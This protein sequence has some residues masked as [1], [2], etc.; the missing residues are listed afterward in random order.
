MLFQIEDV[1]EPDPETEED[2]QDPKTEKGDQ[3]LNLDPLVIAIAI[4][5]QK[6]PA[7][8]LRPKP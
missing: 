6:E 4:M 8:K 7:E 5:I 3:D 1:P 2:V